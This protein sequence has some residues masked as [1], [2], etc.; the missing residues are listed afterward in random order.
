MD[1]EKALEAKSSLDEA[2]K[3]V[4]ANLGIVFGVRLFDEFRERGWLTL[5]TFS[6]LGTQFFAETVPAYDRTHFASPNWDVP[7]WEFRVGKSS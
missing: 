2:L 3:H 7:E 5:E 4:D 6:W 1:N